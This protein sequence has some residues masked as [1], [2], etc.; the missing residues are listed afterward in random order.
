MTDLTQ[1]RELSNNLDRGFYQEA[2]AKG[3]HPLAYLATLDPGDPAE[4]EVKAAQC[5]ARFG[6]QEGTAKGQAVRQY[7]EALPALERQLRLHD[8]K[9]AGPRADTL[10]KFFA[11]SASTVL[12]PAYVESQILAG[13]LSASVFGDLVAT[14]TKIDSHTYESLYMA[15]SEADR[16]LRVVGEGDALPETAISTSEHAVRLRKYG[17][18]L[19]ASYEALRLKR[20]NVVSVFLQRV[21]AQIAIDEVDAALDVI[22]NGD[23][24]D[25]A[26]VAIASEASGTLD[27]DE[28]LR[29]W[30]AFPEP[31]RMN[32]IVA[33]DANIRTLLNLEQFQNPLA[34]M[35]F[36]ATG[37]MISPLGC[38]LHRWNATVA[39][40]WVL[41]IDNRYCLEQVTEQG[42][43]T[44]SDR[45]I[46]RQL[47]RTAITKWTGFVK[48]DPAA[49]AA[50][51][52]THT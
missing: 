13:M 31:Y 20:L 37:D 50:I 22:V 17:R 44:E 51:D 48:M 49:A 15:E 41:G 1:A 3:Y 5:L 11:T 43:T 39:A 40:D 33:R 42:V 46:D 10:E 19:K 21:G 25:N 34:G 47:E 29:L 32:V 52:I 9:V 45:L 38:K 27:Y 24:N 8:I 6:A 12:F 35:K 36:Q 23:G 4:G 16:Q 2:R 28:M 14:E 18:L 30:L 7:A 26:L